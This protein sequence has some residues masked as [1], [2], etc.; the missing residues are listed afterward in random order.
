MRT[1]TVRNKDRNDF[2]FEWAMQRYFSYDI[3]FVKIKSFLWQG[4]ELD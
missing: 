2:D 4:T 3:T 1:K